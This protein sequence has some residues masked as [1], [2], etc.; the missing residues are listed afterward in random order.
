[1]RLVALARARQQHGGMA[2]LVEEVLGGTPPRELPE[3]VVAALAA[4]GEQ[5][6]PAAVPAL[7]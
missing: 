4:I 3:P 2:Q 5:R 7:A 6:R 1:M